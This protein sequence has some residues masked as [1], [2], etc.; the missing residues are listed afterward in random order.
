MVLHELR[1]CNCCWKKS[2]FSFLQNTCQP[3]AYKKVASTFE[4]IQLLQ[5]QVY[6]S[7]K[8]QILSKP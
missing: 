3:N 7:V 5:C 2:H 4:E 8:N 1:L 6:S